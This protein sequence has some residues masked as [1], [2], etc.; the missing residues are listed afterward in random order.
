MDPN[1]PTRLVKPPTAKRRV[2]TWLRATLLSGIV[3][4]AP[5][6]LTIYVLVA[7]ISSADHLLDMLPAELR[8]QSWAFPGAGLVLALVSVLATGFIVR[9]F[10]GRALLD[11]LGRG[12]SR[13]PVASSLYGLF[14]QIA[15]AFLDT[16][17]DKGFKRVVLVEWPREGAW[18][19]AFVTS[20]LD[21]ALAARLPATPGS[22]YLNLF[23]PTTPNPTGGFYAIFPAHKCVETTLGVEEAFKVIIS[24]G[25]L[26][27]AMP[28]EGHKRRTHA[29]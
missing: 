13:I 24:G 17:N 8:T 18:T 19:L 27:P 14:R 4:L 3:A 16:G 2:K 11:W 25:A 23:V 5:L 9:N 21:D 26:G 6:G 20:E 28:L 10:I 22:I 29:G 7:I 15:E 12:I 1:E